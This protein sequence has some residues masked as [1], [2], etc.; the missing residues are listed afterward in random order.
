MKALKITLR[1][2]P[3]ELCTDNAAMVGFFAE[4]KSQSGNATP[5][6]IN[7]GINA[8]WKLSAN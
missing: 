3:F 2:A 5:A 1:M 6:P 8:G 7:L 4:L